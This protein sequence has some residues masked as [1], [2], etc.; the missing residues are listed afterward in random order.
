MARRHGAQDRAHGDA[1]RAQGR[2]PQAPCA[3]S[4]RARA[5]V[6]TD[7]PFVEGA[8]DRGADHDQRARRRTTRHRA[9]SRSQIEKILQ[10]H[11]RA[12]P[13]SQVNYSPGQP[14]LAVAVD[15]AARRRSRASPSRRSRWRCAPR[16]RATRPASCGQRRRT[17]SRSACG[18]TR[19]TARRRKTSL[20][21][22]DAGPARG[23]G[24]A[25][26]RRAHRARRRA[27]RSIERENRER[28]I[29]IWATPT[30]RSLGD[31]VPEFQPQIAKLALAARREL[32]PTTASS[33]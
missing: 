9:A 24:H 10:E 5:I 4:C 18:S 13:T 14:E 12:S 8:R 17:T 22:A 20:A 23:P 33:G 29:T 21:D 26:R 30:G 15:R 32:S 2:R 25:R 6:V 27:R 3:R 1:R 7:P 11:A 16:S 31:V 28:Q 19:A